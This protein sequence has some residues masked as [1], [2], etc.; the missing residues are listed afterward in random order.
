MSRSQDR[1]GSM[2]VFDVAR[3]LAA[4]AVLA[5]HARSLVFL[6][7]PQQ[8]GLGWAG[9]TFFAATGLSHQAVVVFFV[10]SGALVTGSMLGMDADDR[11]SPAQFAIARLSR[12]WVV[13]VPCLLLG[14]VE[15][16]AGLA[17]ARAAGYGGYGLPG[18]DAASVADGLGVGTLAA[19]VMFL[20]GPLL[21]AFGSN[22][23]LWT[24]SMEAWCYALGFAL[25]TLRRTPRFSSAIA[26]LLIGIAAGTVL[27]WT[28]WRL[29]PIWLLGSALAIGCLALRHGGPQIPAL[30]RWRDPVA[31]AVLIL[32]LGATRAIPSRFEGL[33]A[34]AL[35]C[36]TA[37]VLWRFSAR[38]TQGGALQ[39]AASG[40]AGLSYT[41]YL[42]HAPL[43]ALL[44]TVV[45]QHRRL[46]FGPEGFGW[47]TA[48]MVAA[49]MQ[50][51]A[52]W[53]LF[54]RNT[55]RVRALIAGTLPA[56][57]WGVRRR[58]EAAS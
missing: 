39:R 58:R 29:F 22:A 44:S 35:A 13:L 40:L 23:P 1:H 31:I 3:G 17:Q 57:R 12:L 53:W 46:V 50:A 25:F 51:V 19:N 6:D 52:L 10:V 15:D 42:S 18:L 7:A 43:L 11:W 16:W 30:G 34:Y 21:P 4:L 36:A 20:Q 48:A 37:V 28:F 55:P 45:L 5:A 32:V 26:A 41:L 2:V 47:W 38:D 54:E 14:G 8:P 24:L 9:R 49:L 56:R 27:G 33:G